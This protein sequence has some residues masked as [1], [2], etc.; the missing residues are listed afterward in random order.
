MDN[1]VYEIE[2]KFLIRRPD[3]RFLEQRAVGSEIT[4]TYLLSEP[5]ETNRVRARR[6]GDQVSYTHTRKYKINSMRRVEL[7][8]E[9]SKTE[10]ERLLEL[11]DPERRPIRKERWVLEYHGQFFEIDLFPFWER[12]A[13]LELELTDE[14]QAIDFPPELEILR[15]VTGDKRY[16]N[17]ALAREIPPED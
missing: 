1:E 8:R 7:E 3:R 14:E 15:E 6:T 16:T 2:R 12:Q 10:Y 17:A 4:Q 5:G 9:I 13:Y 11:T